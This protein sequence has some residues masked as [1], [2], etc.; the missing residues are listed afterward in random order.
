MLISA[1]RDLLFDAL[2]NLI[3]NAIKHGRE[4]GQVTGNVAEHD[5]RA[6][7]WVADDGT[8]IP[9]A[10]YQPSSGAFIDLSDAVARRAMAWASVSLPPSSAFTMLG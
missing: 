5:G 7:I 3:D 2:S 4:G 1:D 9:A 10:E 6:A 8:G